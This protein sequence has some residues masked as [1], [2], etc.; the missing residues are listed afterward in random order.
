MGTSTAARKIDGNHPVLA[1]RTAVVVEDEGIIQMMLKRTLASA[2]VSVLGSAGS[3]DKAV[4]LV[5]RV[6]PE[7]VLMD[8]EMPVM[9]GIEASRR[10]L[11]QLD[12]CIVVVSAYVDRAEQ[13]LGLVGGFVAKPVDEAVLLRVMEQALLRHDMKR[14][15]GSDGRNDNLS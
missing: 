5:V 1:G 11:A 7:I 12:T 8:I 14:H 10:I 15:L 3:G 9:D 6:Q 2:G 4:E 13:M